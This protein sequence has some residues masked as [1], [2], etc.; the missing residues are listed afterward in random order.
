[1]QTVAYRLERT[2]TIGDGVSRIFNALIDEA[3]EILD[4]PTELG[5]EK[6]VHEV[7][8]RCKEARG[9]LRLVRPALGG[10]YRRTNISLRDAGRALAPIRDAGAMLDTFDAMVTVNEGT[11][12]DSG[13]G[14]IRRE[15]ALRAAYAAEAIVGAEK[16]RLF[17]AR[18]FVVQARKELAGIEIPHSFDPL[19]RGIKKTYRRGRRR[20][21]EASTG[22]S[23]EVFHDWRKRVKYLWYQIR[24][25]Q[26]SASGIL[27]P[28]SGVLHN[29]SD[30]LGDAHNLAGLTQHV[31]RFSG[32]VP[33]DECQ[34]MMKTAKRRRSELENRTLRA[35]RRLYVERPRE[36]TDRIESYWEAWREEGPELPVGEI[37]DLF[38]S[39]DGFTQLSYRE[40]YQLAREADIPGRSSMDREEL[41]KS[42]RSV[43]ALV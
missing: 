43:R 8:K 30:G 12:G 4:D 22:G 11:I 21:A 36:F 24:L 17:T 33:P 7:R 16:H 27:E 40:L 37:E 42:V 13:V 23:V 25:V 10:S 2:E 19:K 14:S 39:G 15:L 18:E 34:A 6:S 41:M 35:G 31:A 5:V 32:Q 1:M 26:D 38:T 20:Q 28:L 3:L 9:L 29:L